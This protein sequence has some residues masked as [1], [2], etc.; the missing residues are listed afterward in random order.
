MQHPELPNYRILDIIKLNRK[1]FSIKTENKSC[2][3]LSCR[4]RGESLFFYNDT[5]RTVKKGDV[6]YIPTGASYA[7]ECE[8]EELICFHLSVSGIVST[9]LDSFSTDDPDRI[10]ALFEKAYKLWKN[11]PLNYEFLCLSVLYEIIGISNAS[12]CLHRNTAFSLPEPA[13]K[14]LHNHLFDPEL[15]LEQACKKAHISRTYFNRL[16]Y[17]TYQCTPITYINQQRIERAKQFLINGNYINEEIAQ[18]CGF[19]DL[20]Y[21][22][23]VFKKYTGMTTQKYKK[24][25]K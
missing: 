5:T 22:Y 9:K 17:D 13:I 19:H 21:F 6:L 7:Q 12:L 14:Y 2:S 1:H 11:K 3:V 15:S 18:L 8:S 16:F 25:H 23:T 24:E 4:T 20:K 10:C